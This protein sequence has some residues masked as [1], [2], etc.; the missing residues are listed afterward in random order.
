M[1]KRTRWLATGVAIGTGGTIWARRRLGS[2]QGQIEP[3][4]V[5]G[6]VA[7]AVAG[8][9]RDRVRAAV[10]EGRA[11]AQRREEEIRTKLEGRQSTDR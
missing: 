10:G 2:L 3:Q 5:V 9:T 8:A 7:G 6:A 11:Q 4:K 1:F